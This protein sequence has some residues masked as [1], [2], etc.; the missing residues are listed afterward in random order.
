MNP[1]FVKESPIL[2][3]SPCQP[4]LVSAQQSELLCAC[5]DKINIFAALDH[6]AMAQFCQHFEIA[7]YPADSQIFAAGSSPDFIYV[8]LTGA[9]VLSQQQR[10]LTMATIKN[11]GCFGQVSAIGIQPR[12]CDAYTL[13]QTQLLRIPTNSLHW[14]HKH[15]PDAFG[16]LIT[17]IAREL[18]RR[19]A[20]ANTLLLEQSDTLC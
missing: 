14:L 6:D 8:V 5:I 3:N 2:P 16:V 9:V 7:Q 19:L 11:G 17:N 15:N 4:Q 18:C 10:Q 1:V 12:M 20:A 13:G